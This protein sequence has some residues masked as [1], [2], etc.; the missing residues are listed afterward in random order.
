MQKGS[1][2]GINFGTTNTAV[3]HLQNDEQG[4]R[5]VNLGEG[6]GEYPFSSVVAVP[7]NGGALKFGREVKD[8]REELSAD[9]EIFTSMKS[10]LGTNKE[11]KVGANRYTATEITSE[12]L[13]SVKEYIARVHNIEIKEAGLAFPID[14]SPE[15]RSELRIAAENAGITV[16][17]FV[18]ESTAA[19]LSSREKVRA[20]SRVMVLDWGGGTFDISILDLKKN[21]VTE[22]AVFGEKVG[23]DDIDMELAR[24]VHAEIVKKS[25]NVAHIPFDDM[26]PTD[27]DTMVAHCER[28]KIEISE[29]VTETDEDYD[30]T[31]MDYGMYGTKTVPV[32]V[33]YFDE[34][35]KPIIHNRILRSIDK[36][37]GRA[38]MT[39]AGIDAVI[40]IGGSS[41]LSA[42]E[43]AITNLFGLDKIILTDKPQWSTAIGAAMMQI[44][45]GNFKLSD[46]LGVLLSDDFIFPLFEASKDGV[47]SKISPIDF[48]LV[49]DTQNANFIFVNKD[50]EGVSNIT[51]ERIAVPAKGFLN[52]KIRLSGAIA[53]DQIAR[54]NITN[55]YMGQ[56]AIIASRQVEINK[57][58]FFY[59]L[60]DLNQ[61]GRDEE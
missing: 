17:C 42:Y 13:K 43:R 46:T 15:A 36:A 26:N 59:D 10:F 37:L 30:L 4:T 7:K 49:E 48:S 40:I 3:V 1:F 50:E 56:S 53:D 14:F 39:T 25:A 11:F 32:S 12:F 16:K 61:G 31:V 38:N 35:V 57:L 22:I 45:G 6:G 52:E 23:G 28:A 19:Y 24:R 41:N 27:R 34:L 29:T 47:G 2:I 58:T 20:F 54:I 60:T 8:R 18:S 21:A 55:S 33:K 9:Y 51:Y 5:I 44:I